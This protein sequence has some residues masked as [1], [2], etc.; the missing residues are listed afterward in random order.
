MPIKIKPILLAVLSVFLVVFLLFQGNILGT[1]LADGPGTGSTIAGVEVSG[2]DE[3]EMRAA[4]QE[5]INHWVSESIVVTDGEHEVLVDPSQF[6][7]DLDSTVTQYQ[8]T[9][10]K[11]WFAFW[12]SDQVVQLPIHITVP[13]DLKNTIAVVSSWDAEATL[14][15]ITTQASY[16]KEHEIAAVQNDLTQLENERI[17]L[18]IVTI[19]TE[20]IAVSKIAELINETILYPGETFSFI[21]TVGESH[22]TN[23]AKDF[24]ASVLYDAVLNTEFQ[25]VERHSQEKIPTYLEPGINARIS[26]QYNEDLQFLNSSTNPVKINATIEGSDLKL[27]IYSNEKSKEVL[28]QTHKK[29]IPPRIIN[30]YSDDLVVG[31]KQLV[32]EGEKG[33]RVVVTR[34]VS[35]SGSTTEEQISRDYY[36]PANRIVLISARQPESIG[37]TDSTG[38]TSDNTY[39]TDNTDSTGTTN[40]S[41]A[42]SGIENQD[43]DTQMD[44]DNNGL[45]DIPL[46]EAEEN[47]PEGSYY[48]KGGNLIT[49]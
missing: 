27:E 32:Q 25:I 38:T 23:E 41:T 26:I 46:D 30:R 15:S 4:L 10:E 2:L 13:E 14:N 29:E 11:P 5:A 1:A 44:L 42:P 40:P 16:L 12:E 45:P 48:D 49:P 21:S 47:L 24:V 35:E 18:S 43:P 20:S 9:V 7:F 22:A 19:P 31:Q 17:A 37:T 3:D 6:V 28:V 39:P 36:A 33:L 34:I 8:T